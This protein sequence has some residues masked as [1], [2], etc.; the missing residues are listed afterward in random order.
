[1]LARTHDGQCTFVGILHII[2]AF[3]G[4]HFE[5]LLEQKGGSSVPAASYLAEAERNSIR[6]RAVRTNDNTRACLR[7]K[8][9]PGA[10]LF[11]P[12]LPSVDVTQL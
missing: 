9:H 10:A 11:N 12:E 3:S 4:T 1:V 8:T 6:R 2:N 7:I 5:R